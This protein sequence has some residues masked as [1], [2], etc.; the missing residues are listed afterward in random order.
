MSKIGWARTINTTSDQVAVL[1]DE[2]TNQDM[3]GIVRKDHRGDSISL[4]D[5]LM[6]KEDETR[7]A[8]SA[9]GKKGASKRYRDHP[10]P[11]ASPI[12]DP[13]GG[14]RVLG[15]GYGS[16]KESEEGRGGDCASPA[17]G[18]RDELDGEIHGWFNQNRLMLWSQRAH[19]ELRMLV[20]KAGWPEAKRLMGMSYQA[21]IPTSYALGIL[22]KEQ[23]KDVSKPKHSAPGEWAKKEYTPG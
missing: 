19:N 14:S 1:L 8:L 7:R 17:P 5:V 23:L 20:E 18:E 22:N 9:A 2:L 16:G 4:T 11:I 6:V 15:I 21:S 3:T 13:I 10:D 12:A